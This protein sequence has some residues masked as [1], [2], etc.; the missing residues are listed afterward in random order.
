MRNWLLPLIACL[1]MTTVFAVDNESELSQFKR[2]EQAYMQKEAKKEALTEDEQIQLEKS[3]AV[4]NEIGQ[5]KKEL[6][7]SYKV[8]DKDRNLRDDIFAG[9]LNKMLP[10]SPKQIMALR[11]LYTETQKAAAVASVPAPKP[12]ASSKSVDLSP[13]ATPPVVR[14]AA[15]FITSLVFLD[16]TGQPWP[17]KAYSLGDPASYNIQWDQ[18]SNNLLVQSLTQSK[19]GNL[20]VVL[21][22]L[23]TP[24]MVTLMPGQKAVDYRI[25]LH[26]PGFGPQAN[27]VHSGTPGKA[28]SVLQEVLDGVAP[29][30][31]K[32]LTVSGGGAQAWMLGSKMYIRT[33]LI[34]LSPGW[35]A[36]MT[37]ADGTNAYELQKTPV[38]LASKHG[39]TTELVIEDF[40]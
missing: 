15:G 11:Q 30:N 38:L 3:K 21:Q 23:D 6:S 26:V 35:I 39:K 33:Q 14:L 8:K 27:P 36:K 7:S 13:G 24:V 28:N 29:T 17:V 19:A 4:N 2:M 9:V 18:T 31:S 20:A 22:H 16:A 40:Q 32:A 5:L 10:I 1:F 37:S 34:L 12:T 25:D